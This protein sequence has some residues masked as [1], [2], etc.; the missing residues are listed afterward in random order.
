LLALLLFGACD[1]SAPSG[2][3]SKASSES[4]AL[5][6]SICRYIARCMPLALRMFSKD[7]VAS[8]EAS[9]TCGRGGLA[10]LAGDSGIARPKPS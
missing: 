10:A 7:A 4:S 2:A 5:A 1:R 8:C 9:F 6:V 3:S